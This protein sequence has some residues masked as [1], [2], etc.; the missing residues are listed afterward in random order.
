MQNIDYDHIKENLIKYLSD[1]KINNELI[2]KHKFLIR[3]QEKK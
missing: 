3:E 2:T 1:Y